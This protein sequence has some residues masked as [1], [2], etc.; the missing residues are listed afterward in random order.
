MPYYRKL[1]SGSHSYVVRLPNGRRKSFTDPLKRVA[2]QQA[3]DFE[4]QLRHGVSMHL[5]DKKLTVGEWR[6]KWLRAR[7]VDPITEKKNAS[8]WR[9]HIEPQWGSWPLTS[10]GRLDVQTWIKDMEAAGVGA[11]TIAAAYH[12]F[13]GMLKAAVLDKKLSESPCVAIDLPTVVKPPP[14]WLTRLEHDRIQLALEQL[15][16]GHV[17]QALVGLGCFSGLRPVGELAG[18]DVEDV[19]FER[20]M[21]YVHQVL[22]RAGMREYPKTEGS[23]RWVPFPPHVGQLLWRVATERRTGPLFTAARGGRMTEENFRN[24][25]WRPALATAGV[26][27]ETPYVMRHTAASWLVQAGVPPFE[28]VKMLGHSSQRLVNTYLHLAP[29]QH[30][31]IRTAWEQPSRRTGG[32]TG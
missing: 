27:P 11:P 12:L 30:D 1:P 24:R 10:I 7:R 3:E 15:P 4:A 29:D 25:V 19:D 9:V 5:H 16:R 13:A 31:R 2:K 28:I 17:W 26:K 20:G 22:T 14:R 18:L 8:H 21:V 6:A 32:A 23:V